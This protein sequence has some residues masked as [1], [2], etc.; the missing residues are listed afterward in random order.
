MGFPEI[1]YIDIVRRGDSR[2]TRSFE[3][4]MAGISSMSAYLHA[5]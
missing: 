3:M 2:F 5:A 1:E 4:L